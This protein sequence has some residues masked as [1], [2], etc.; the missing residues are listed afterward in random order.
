MDDDMELLQRLRASDEQ[1]FVILVRRYHDPMLRLACGF[2][3]SRAVAEEVV[4]D[5]WMGVLR[6]ISG[7]EGRSSLRTWLFRILV[8]RARTAGE[9]ERRSVA[10]GDAGP[11]VDQSRFDDAGSWAAP[12]EQWIEDTDDRLRAGKLA[13]RIR[14]A[15]E[16][17]PARQREV[18]TLR[19]VEGLSSHEVCHVLEITD[20]NQRVLLHRG[21]SRV[22]QVL[23]T[24]FGR[25]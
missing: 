16:E 21:R 2:V 8:N 17:L 7:F 6:G 11:A 5:T 1:A 4:Q 18:V 25:A 10:I 15:I 12:P 20:G 9:R 19:D 24:E 3:P 13:G 23:E 14:S 22:R